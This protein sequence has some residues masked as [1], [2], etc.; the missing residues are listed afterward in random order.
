M[1]LIIPMISTKKQFELYLGC[2]NYAWAQWGHL[3]FIRQ[4]RMSG[5]QSGYYVQSVQTRLPKLCLCIRHGH[6]Y[7]MG[8]QLTYKYVKIHRGVQHTVNPGHSLCHH[9]GPYIHISIYG[10]KWWHKELMVSEPLDTYRWHIRKIVDVSCVVWTVGGSFSRYADHPT[11][12]HHG[13]AF[14][15]WSVRHDF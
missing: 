5:Q 2:L 6:S 10:Q 12:P 14:W 3:W 8:F 15:T 11:T 9:F 7:M 4:Q 13:V 1:G